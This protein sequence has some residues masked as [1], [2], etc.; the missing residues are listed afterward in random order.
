MITMPRPRF[1][2]AMLV[3][4][5][6]AACAGR[7]DGAPVTYGR[8]GQ[9]AGI[10]VVQSGDALYKIADRYKVSMRDLIAINKLQPPYNLWVGQRLVLPSPEQYR[11]QGGDTLYSISRSFGVDM[12][13]LARTNRLAPPYAVKVGQ[14][15]RLPGGRE[16]AKIA[17]AQNNRAAKDVDVP[18]PG[19]KPS[20]VAARIESAK[21]A[22]P[23]PPQQPREK[24]PAR[25]E[26]ITSSPQPDTEMAQAEPVEAA[27]PA[28]ETPAAIPA[29]EPAPVL[30]PE[31]SHKA[32][33]RRAGRFIW[34]VNGRMISGYGAKDGGLHND[35][36]NVAAPN[37]SPVRAAEN[38]V[39]A[40]AG[41]ELKGFGNLLLIRHSDGWMTAYAHLDKML[42]ERGQSVVQGQT[43]AT[44]GKTGSVDVPQL[45]F[46]IRRGSRALDPADYLDRQ[47]V[48]G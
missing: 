28:P 4:C 21:P 45:H 11:V 24:P 36:I 31:I 26:P 30:K 44:V 23:T 19:R 41:D 12:T 34:P 38:G 18:L 10:V 42:V 37:G 7:R 27:E 1:L 16:G 48:S 33:P 2:V 15:L 20:V 14:M 25:D 9:G 47:G 39:V 5:L 8:G 6:L 35:G 13:E 17:V 43:I 3:L 40:Y 22:K 46:E 32:A 29:P